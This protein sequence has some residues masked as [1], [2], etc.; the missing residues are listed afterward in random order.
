MGSFEK[1]DDVFSKLEEETLTLFKI[2]NTA[3]SLVFH[4]RTRV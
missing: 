4:Y 1:H 3:F 2:Q